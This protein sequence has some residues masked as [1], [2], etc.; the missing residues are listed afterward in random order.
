MT[1]VVIFIH[2]QVH[3]HL[4]STGLGQGGQ[5]QLEEGVD[6]RAYTKIM[7]IVRQCEK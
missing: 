4:A 5:V 3:F 7:L 6:F 1:S 2:I